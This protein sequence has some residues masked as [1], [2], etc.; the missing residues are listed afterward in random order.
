MKHDPTFWILARAAG[1]TAYVLL[2]A[3]MVAGL[4]LKGRVL[5]RAVRPAAVTDVH[6]TLAV[7]GLAALALH[8][9]A[10]VLDA[11]VR[12]TPLGLLVPG[13]VD[14][15][16]WWTGAGVVAGELM[17]LVTASFWMRKRIGTRLWRH[18]HWLSYAAFL[19]A[20][21]HG[22]LAGSD[23]N[24]PWA[25][26]IYASAAGVVGAGTAWRGLRR[27][28]GSRQPRRAGSPAA[29]GGA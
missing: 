10:L 3:S 5:G 23:A 28:D 12:V 4:T 7:A 16:S 24:R 26:A 6:K 14:Y 11:T 18:L 17:A 15:R 25:I 13:L 1:L 27:A 19:L 22:L 20:T 29:A 9:A 8:G 21:V 2:T